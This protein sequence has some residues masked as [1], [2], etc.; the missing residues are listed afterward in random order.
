MSCSKQHLNLSI[1]SLAALLWMG[2]PVASADNGR[3]IALL[4]ETRTAAL[5]EGAWAVIHAPD[6]R[7]GSLLMLRGAMG[8]A[9]VT[10]REM[11]DAW[12][13]AVPLRLLLGDF[14]GNSIAI[15]RSGPALA[16]VMNPDIAQA[17]RAGQDIT[18]DALRVFGMQQALAQPDAGFDIVLAGSASPENG[19]VL[20]MGSSLWSDIF[21]TPA[22]LGPC[23]HESA[24][25]AL[26]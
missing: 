20:N 16:L 24:D 11:A 15:G 14:S 2:L 5:T 10:F 22:I 19:F 7:R 17:M 6:M 21:G 8:Q 3:P 26:R 25:A 18:S 4:Q 1:T 23:T 9:R 13:P 12:C